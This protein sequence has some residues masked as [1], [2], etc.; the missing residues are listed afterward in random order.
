[1]SAH[2]QFTG[3]GSR[4]AGTQTRPPAAAGVWPDRGDLEP[5][6]RALTEQRIALTILGIGL[7]AIYGPLAAG[8]LL[9]CWR[10]ENYSH[11]VLVPLVVLW[12]VLQRRRDVID[13][14]RRA[15]RR[16][17]AVAWA[18]LVAGVCAFV[19]GSAAAELFTQR[20]SGVL[21][22]TGL[23]GVLGGPQRL[24]R[25]GPALALLACAVP[26]PYVVYYAISFPM[27]LLS[28][29]LAAGTLGLLQLDVARS[30][31]IF[32]VN[33]HALEVVGACSGI[34]SM[35]ALCT[36]ALV[37]AVTMRLG[38]LRGAVLSFASLPVALC[39]NILRLATTA[40]LVLW[41]GERATRGTLHESVGMVTFIVSVVL[42]AGILKLLRRGR[43]SVSVQGS[44]RFRFP[45]PHWGTLRAWFFAVRL[46]SAR[47]AWIA[48]ALVA[49][50][51]AYGVW[52]RAHAAEPGVA[53][54]L[55]R[56]PLE[57]AGFA[58]EDIPLDDRVLDKLQPESFVFRNYE[59]ADMSPI[60]L[61]VAYYRDPRE[62][63]QIH[64]PLH[65]YPGAGWKV[66]DSDPLE[67][68]DLEGRPTRMQRLLVRKGDRVD[69]VVYWYDTRTGRMT[70]DFDLKLNLVRTALLHA[71]RDAAF[72]RW[73]T[74]L[75]PGEDPE[76]ATTRLLAV[77]A[78]AYADLEATLPFGG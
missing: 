60:G 51:G 8:T 31:N 4:T 71:P 54:Q 65:C 36:V 62:G 5:G 32:E 52:L 19:I 61:Y 28:A 38:V 55:E 34:R 47:N 76:S 7:L 73:S 46:V 72:V 64:S 59:R 67:V 53:P 26:L 9:D 63:A 44:E 74:P 35:M 37:A 2:T 15:A 70:S 23:A 41:I 14:S 22:I 10:D 50:S 78:H 42:L 68:R 39:G 12:L 1:M 77:V 27:Q 33:G 29:R 25:Y 43:R 40:L 13:V 69:V 58:G 3:H 11:G 16:L 66:V 17:Q 49:V 24:R 57:F 21:V 75:A 48:V 18:L 45:R 56:L 6:R 30:G 20:M